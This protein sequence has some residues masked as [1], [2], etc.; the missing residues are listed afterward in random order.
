MPRALA[1][2]SRRTRV[3]LFTK[4]RDKVA[5]PI[6]IKSIA[7]RLLLALIYLISLKTI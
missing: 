6:K 1:S 5:I 4:I 7:I 2:Y 3:A